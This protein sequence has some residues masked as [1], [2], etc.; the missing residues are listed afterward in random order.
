[1]QKISRTFVFLGY[2]GHS[3]INPEKVDLIKFPNILKIPQWFYANIQAGDCLYLPTQMWHV[4]HSHGDQNVAVAFLLSQFR[5]ETVKNLNLEN[6][7]DAKM[8]P[9]SLDQVYQIKDFTQK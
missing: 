8:D 4:V 5:D 1:M 7:A 9:V 3:L 6:C 2:G